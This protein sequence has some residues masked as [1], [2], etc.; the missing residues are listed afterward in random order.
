MDIL[1]ILFGSFACGGTVAHYFTQYRTCIAIEWNLVYTFC[2]KF[3]PIYIII[4]TIGMDKCYNVFTYD[5]IFTHRTLHSTQHAFWTVTS[6]LLPIVVTLKGCSKGYACGGES[7][8]VYIY[9]FVST[10]T[11]LRSHKESSKDLI[12]EST[13]SMWSSYISHPH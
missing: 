12:T 4:R 13:Q 1:Q 10:H 6:I 5:P 3:F 11:A 8:N 9:G 2:D 7:Y